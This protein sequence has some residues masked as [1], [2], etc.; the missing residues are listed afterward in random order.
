[1]LNLLW[2]LCAQ[3]EANGQPVAEKTAKKVLQGIGYGVAVGRK[4]ASV[5]DVEA[6]RRNNPLRKY[7]KGLY[8]ILS[9]R[10]K[11]ACGLVNRPKDGLIT[12]I[13]ATDVDDELAAVEYVYDIYKFYKLTE[14]VDVVLVANTIAYYVACWFNHLLIYGT[15]PTPTL[16]RNSSALANLN[17]IMSSRIAS[18]PEIWAP[19]VN[20]FIAIS[21]NAYS[22]KQGL[23][24]EK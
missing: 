10:S 8:S 23:L 9:A 14:T 22:R 19:E 21:D 3:L 13:Y 1:M 4:G 2:G 5:V 11:V 16:R 20:D 7:S 15:P 12:N 24:M 18:K 6:V 17:N